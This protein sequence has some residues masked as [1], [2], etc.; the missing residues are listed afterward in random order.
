MKKLAQWIINIIFIGVFVGV[1]LILMK[2]Y[3]KTLA[4][5]PKSVILL[6]GLLCLALG[7]GHLLGG[8]FLRDLN[9]RRV[10]V[11]VSLLIIAM[12]FGGALGMIL[13]K[14][15][16]QK[17]ELI[18]PTPLVRVQKVQ[19]QDLQMVVKGYGTVAPKT[20]VQIVPQV[21]GRVVD[22]SPNLVNGGF[23]EAD[24]ALITIDPR[25][26]E[27]AVESAQAQV[28]RARTRLDTEQAEAQVA[29]QEWAQLNPGREPANALVFR[30]PQIR[31]AQ[32]E[33]SAAEASLARARLDLERTVIKLPFAGRVM[34]E[35]VDLSQY[36][37]AGQQI[38]KVYATDTVQV[39]VPLED[40]ELQWFDVP[41]GDPNKASDALVLADFAGRQHEWK[42][43][44]VRT[45]GSI[46][47]AS[48]VVNVVVEVSNPFNTRKTDTAL[49]PGMFVEVDILGRVSENVIKVPRY[50]AHN[51]NEVWVV[52]N[53]KLHIRP[54]EIIRRDR[55]YVYVRS[56]LDDAA[57]IVTT[58]MDTVTDGMDIRWEPDAEKEAA[59]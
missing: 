57:L 10:Q 41:N 44:V 33:L 25:D 2:H 11:A 24:E 26:Y 58:P 15:P 27:L 12:G 7:V 36:L 51:G 34:S 48:R 49:V 37:N 29:R 53:D 3:P 59:L 32:A 35:S 40:R 50:A 21:S 13:L 20:E 54:V 42:G 5:K 8:V 45:E 47:P 23:F 46:D 18:V 56:G 1:Y 39:V 9:R 17:K 4:V 31:Q 30:E 28:A 19:R 16:P 22:L 14:R 38:A 6:L 52:N 43:R 55:G